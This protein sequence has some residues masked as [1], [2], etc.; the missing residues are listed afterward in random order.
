MKVETVRLTA[1]NG[2][3]IRITT[4]VTLDDGRACTFMER[5]STAQAIEQA[6]RYFASGPVADVAREFEAAE[7]AAPPIAEV[8]FS[9][10]PTFGKSAG[11]QEDLF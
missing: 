2:R 5:L 9:L 8:P 1:A 10:T 3:P 11:K 7:R 4:R 6:R